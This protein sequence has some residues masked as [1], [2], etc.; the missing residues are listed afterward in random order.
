MA[1]SSSPELPHIVSLVLQSKKALQQG[2]AL[3]SR[4]HT[5]SNASAQTAFD[6]LAAESKVKWMTDAVLE[7]L[8]VCAPLPK[9]VSIQA[10]RM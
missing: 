1:S 9:F 4:A 7:Q 5:V 3:C 8:K 10:H 2:E 6:L